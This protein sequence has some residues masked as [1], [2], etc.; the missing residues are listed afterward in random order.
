MILH[1]TMNPL[2]GCDRAHITHMLR[3]T[4]EDIASGYFNIPSRIPRKAQHLRADIWRGLQG[5]FAAECSWR[6]YSRRSGI[7]VQVKNLRC[8]L[9]GYAYL[10]RFEWVLH[11]IESDNF[12]V[13]HT[14]RKE[15][16]S[17]F[18]DG[19]PGFHICITQ[20]KTRSQVLAL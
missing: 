10:A 2:P 9:A 12:K 15:L 11:M 6:R 16:G 4:P 7:H 18:M 3:D 8:R 17:R 1:P 20:D 13:P 5:G 19:Q 14:Q